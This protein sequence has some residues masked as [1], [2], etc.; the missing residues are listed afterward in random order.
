MPGP[1]PGTPLHL[2]KL[3]KRWLYFFLVV[4]NYHNKTGV[5][6]CTEVLT[7][8]RLQAFARFPF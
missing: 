2:V 3:W 7:D 4:G 6:S 1:G 5:V 8:I